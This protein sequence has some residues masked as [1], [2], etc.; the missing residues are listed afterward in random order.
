MNDMAV[1]FKR[2]PF[3]VS[4]YHHLFD[5]GVLDDRARVELIDGELIEMP[6]I[7][8]QHISRHILITRYLIRT[9]DDRA[10][11][12]PMGS[13]P[14]G[15]FNEPQPDL[16]I[17]PYDRAAYE[18]QPFPSPDR[19]VAFI[20]IAASSFSY[21]SGIKMKLYARFGIP[22]YLLVDVLK[23]RLVLYRDPSPDGYATV[24]ELSYD[25]IFTLVNLP[26]LDLLADAFL[27][28]R[29]EALSQ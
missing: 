13:F 14:L 18:N 17:F 8:P 21:D 26:D 29:D 11:V 7:G 2:Y 22:D 15:D 19:F 6:P 4:E 1:E 12:A 28:L 23:N 16:A 25:D 9:L 24:R 3:T 20:E 5:A 10:T 27:G